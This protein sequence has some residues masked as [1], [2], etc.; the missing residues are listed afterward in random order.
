MT[1]QFQAGDCP[2][3]LF[4]V[5]ICIGLIRVVVIIV[6]PVLHLYRINRLRR[7]LITILL[8]AKITET[9][10]GLHRSRLCGRIPGILPLAT[11]LVAL[12]TFF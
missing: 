9:S 5:I 1:V 11:I 12:D 4:D 10:N 6:N 7:M 8:N 3:K 2:G